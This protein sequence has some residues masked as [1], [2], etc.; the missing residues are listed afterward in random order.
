MTT[1]GTILCEPN[2]SVRHPA[3]VRLPPDHQ[4]LTTARRSVGRAARAHPRPEPERQIAASRLVGPL[5]AAGYDQ[6]SKTANGSVMSGWHPGTGWKTSPDASTARER[7]T[8]SVTSGAGPPALLPRTTYP[9]LTVRQGRGTPSDL[10]HASSC[11][12]PAAPM[13]ARSARGRAACEKRW[14][15]PRAPCVAA[16]A[17]PRFVPHVDSNLTWGGLLMEERQR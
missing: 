16:V 6:P 3:A 12:G 1:V 5:R 15:G 8:S 10:A 11:R 9:G 14:M 13:P 17:L 7:V 4:V 2:V